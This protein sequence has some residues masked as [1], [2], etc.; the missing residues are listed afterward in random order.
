MASIRLT[1]DDDL[2]FSTGNL[3][4]ITGAE[5]VA[6][7]VKI[8]LRFFLGEWFRDTRLG[9]DHHGITFRK[10]VGDIERRKLFQSIVLTTPGVKQL[11][12]FSFEFASL[13]RR[14]TVR[15]RAIVAGADE[16]ID[17]NEEFIL[18]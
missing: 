12:S 18:T 9:A 4:L 2:D 6:Q 8:R 1:A 3:V 5:E 10:T 11:L 17:F 13:T 15:F 16:P 14:L 7:K